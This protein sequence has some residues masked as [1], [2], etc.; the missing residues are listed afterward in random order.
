MGIVVVVVE[1]RLVVLPLF[2][3]DDWSVGIDTRTWLN[4]P[5]EGGAV[6]LLCVVL[7]PEGGCVDE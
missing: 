5:A 6:V 4:S 7:L 3:G 2:D 1:D